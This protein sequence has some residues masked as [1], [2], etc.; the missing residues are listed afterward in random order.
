M[1]LSEDSRFMRMMGTLRE[2]SPALLDRF[3]HVDQ[4]SS[5]AF[6]AVAGPIESETIIGVARYACGAGASEGEFAIAV[7]DEWQSRGVGSTLLQVLFEYARLRG[8][9][10][11]RGLVLASNERMLDLAR[12][13]LMTLSRDPAEATLIEVSR[14]F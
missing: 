9:R 6:V 3:V 11:L 1:H 7:A 10:C 4:S 13:H 12:K 2:P 8:L 14:T 5:M